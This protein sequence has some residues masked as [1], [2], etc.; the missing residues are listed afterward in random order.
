M[1]SCCHCCWRIFGGICMQGVDGVINKALMGCHG[2]FKDAWSQ[3][4]IKVTASWAATYLQAWLTKV[5]K[6]LLCTSP[7]YVTK[8]RVIHYN[9]WL[10][11]HLARRFF[12][13]VVVVKERERESIFSPGS[14]SH[15]SASFLKK[16][17]KKTCLTSQN[18]VRRYWTF[19]P[20]VL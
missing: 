20:A 11:L 2:S 7:F 8:H 18:R 1:Q 9:V 15:C 14:S 17:Q 5:K 10:C 12:F 13:L 19:F 4:E 16:K 3:R 6:E